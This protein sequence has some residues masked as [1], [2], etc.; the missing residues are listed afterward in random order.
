MSSKML[1]PKKSHRVRN[2]FLI[3]AALFV[4]IIVIANL[5]PAQDSTAPSETTTSSQATT[6]PSPTPV[7]ATTTPESTPA[8]VA[9][10]PEPSE[11]EPQLIQTSDSS[12]KSVVV[13][14]D[15]YG[16]KWPL[17]VSEARVTLI[18]KY[19]AVLYAEGE[20]YALNGTAQSRGYAPI[21]PIWRDNPEIPGAKVSISPL[22]QLALSLG[23]APV[24]E[25]TSPRVTSGN[26]APKPQA[27]TTPKVRQIAASVSFT[28]T[29]FAI[30]NR[31]DHDWVNVRFELNPGLISSGYTLKVQLIEA[32]TTY[33]VGAMQFANS[34]GE[35]FNPYQMKPQKFNIVDFSSEWPQQ[36]GMEGLASFGWQ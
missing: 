3:V 36:A 4:G 5:Q 21:N 10:S 30:T 19:V 24:P 7:A 18:D 25:Q 35:R 14:A 28:G 8:P 15:E 6:Q 32:G 16:D 2:F 17:T 31:E 20:T 33:T 27:D 23:T 11:P 12:S 22:I 13:T 26:T 9:T 1:H 34:K 29:Q